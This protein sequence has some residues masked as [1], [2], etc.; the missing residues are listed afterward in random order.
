MSTFY[1]LYRYW[2]IESSQ[3]S[4]GVSFSIHFT[5]EETEGKSC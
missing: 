4:S 2:P 5:E 1:P 3:Q